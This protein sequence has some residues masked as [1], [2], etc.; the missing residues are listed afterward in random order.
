MNPLKTPMR[1]CWSI[2]FLKKMPIQT[3]YCFSFQDAPGPRTLVYQP[4]TK[5]V[6]KMLTSR[7][8][9]F[10]WQ[11]HRHQL[12]LGFWLPLLVPHTAPS[13]REGSLLPFQ[14]EGTIGASILPSYF[15]GGAW[16]YQFIPLVRCSSQICPVFRNTRD[17]FRIPR[18]LRPIHFTGEESLTERPKWLNQGLLRD[19]PLLES[20]AFQSK[21]NPHSH[22]SLLLNPQLG[23]WGCG[24]KRLVY[25]AP[26]AL[27]SFSPAPGC[28]L[29]LRSCLQ[30]SWSFHNSH[31]LL[32]GPAWLWMWPYSWGHYVLSLLIVSNSF[33]QRGHTLIR[34]V[35]TLSLFFSLGGRL[36][37]CLGDFHP[38]LV[39]VGCELVRHGCFLFFSVLLG[40]LPAVVGVF[41]RGL[42][43]GAL[44][45]WGPPILAHS[46]GVCLG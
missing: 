36:S 23:S 13:S 16:W 9:S 5:G 21:S 27:L 25:L 26:Q 12:S 43:L 20:T 38:V 8:M 3:K 33:A 41:F 45:W 2:T 30:G 7:D 24:M 42:S 46:G 17:C 18:H 22:T 14:Q 19:Q 40:Q 44:G 35:E 6:S 37:N 15:L 32:Y 11:I 10:N 29:W 28:P 31:F 34:R 4:R 39:N 1:R